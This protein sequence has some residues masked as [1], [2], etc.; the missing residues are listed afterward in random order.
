MTTLNFALTRDRSRATSPRRRRD[1]RH[2]ARPRRERLPLARARRRPRPRRALRRRA[3]RLHAR[4]RRPGAQLGDETRVVAFPWASN[5]VGTINDVPRIADAR[6][7][8]RRARLGGRRPLRA[9][10]ADRRRGR[11]RDVLLCSPYKFFGPH[12]GLFF[13]RA[14]LL[15][16]LAPV[17]GAARARRAC[18][19]RASRPARCRTSSSPASSPRSS[20]SSRS[21]GTRSS[22]RSAR[23]ASASSADSPTA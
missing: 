6:A 20:T 22:R 13:G 5:A 18:S 9:A 1:P 7:R 10:R 14:E 4:P 2:A 21:A 11:G 23:S 16:R 15:E 12:L 3:R 17:Q 8:G 19:P